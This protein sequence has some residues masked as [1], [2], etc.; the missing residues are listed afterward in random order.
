MLLKPYPFIFI[1]I[2]GLCF[3]YF[4]VLFQDFLFL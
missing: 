4:L 2:K 1:S 3:S